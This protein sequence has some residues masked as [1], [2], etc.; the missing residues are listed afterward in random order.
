MVA[1]ATLAVIVVLLVLWIESSK[2]AAF[3]P[4]ALPDQCI[5]VKALMNRGGYDREELLKLRIWYMEH[6]DGSR[7]RQKSRQSD[8]SEVEFGEQNGGQRSRC[9]GADTRLRWRDCTCPGHR[10]AVPWYCFGSGRVA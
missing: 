4:V 5:S 9:H 2:G 6:C 8:G 3:G 1:W 10:V 7:Y